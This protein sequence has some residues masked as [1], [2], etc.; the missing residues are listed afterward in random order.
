VSL[1]IW[2]AKQNRLVQLAACVLCVLVSSGT[3]GALA[4]ACSGVTIS[5]PLPGE[6]LRSYRASFKSPTRLA[7]DHN[8]NVYIADPF[9]QRILVRAVT[10]QVALELSNL[11]FP[12][13][14][15]VDSSGNI[16]VGEGNL[17][18]VDIYDAGG[19]LV[20]FLGS[21]DGEFA[22]PAHIAIWESGGDIHVYVVDSNADRISRYNGATGMFELD[23]GTSGSADG[24]MIFPSGIAIENNE[25]IIV[26][27]GN[28]R[29]QVFDPAGMFIRSFQPDQ[30]NC[31]FLCF[32]EGASRGR[33]QDSSL[34][35][36]PTGDLYMSQA[37]KGSVLV[38]T[39]DGSTLGT[40][41]DYGASP[42][43]LRVP[44]DAVI[45]SCGRLYVAS[46]AN[47]RV[48]IYGLPGYS[49]PEQF[50]PG[51][52]RTPD[53][54]VD[55]STATQV[56]LYLEFP[57]HPPQDVSGEL[58]NGVFTPI[59]QSI[60]DFDQNTVPDLK[61]TFGSDFLGTLSGLNNIDVTV[62]GNLSTL[63]FAETATLTLFAS[64]ADGDG[65]PDATDACLDTA[66]GDITRDDGCSVSQLCPCSGIEGDPWPSRGAYVRCVANTYNLFFAQG[67]IDRQQR[68]TIKQGLL[69]AS[70]GTN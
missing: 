52:L 60:G 30:D 41:G 25:L 14:L 8:D 1:A 24:E 66:I 51:L 35:V 16:Y 70:C 69:G 46:A 40:I 63:Q 19:N 12:V 20:G 44:S 61:L 34:W 68:R 13:S 4:A 27:R 43:L 45:D 53:Q 9:N 10:G 57:G 50:A 37:S 65:V 15:A 55:L 28:S 7:I 59:A 5:A 39:N 6:F 64:D 42:G 38:M 49:D 2:K 11:D 56:D 32:F 3:S 21:G 22:L 18:R 31:G 58:L 36:G 62:T 29:L 54:P 48:E 67:H 23:F 26:D 33:A 47:S 17:G